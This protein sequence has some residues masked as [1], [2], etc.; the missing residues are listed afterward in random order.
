MSGEAAECWSKPEPAKKGDR[1]EGTK[2][3]G[4]DHLTLY[5][6]NAL[7]ASTFYVGRFGMKRV[8]YQGLETKQSNR[9]RASHVLQQGRI[10][11]KLVSAY[12]PGDEEFNTFMGAHGDAVK[13][14][15]FS[16]EN[17]RALYKRVLDAGAES[18]KEP[19]ELSDEN[20][21]VVIATIKSYGDVTHTF[22]ERR[23]YH[24][25]FLPGYEPVDGDKDPFT[26]ITAPVEL[27]FIDHVVGNHPDHCMTPIVEWY[28]KVFNFHRFWSVDD[29]IMHT[30]YSALNSTVMTDYDEVIKL[31]TNEPAKGKKKSQIQEYIDYHGGAGV[32]HVALNTSNILHSVALLKQRGLDFLTVP[33]TY[34]DRLREKLKTAAIKVEEDLDE[35]EKLNIL[36]DYDE[37]GYLLQIFTKP[38]EDRPT[39]FY[40]IIQRHNHYG[41]GAGNFKSLFEAIEK[42]QD[43]RGNLN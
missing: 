27:G 36:I 31:P 5:V 15:A 41:F 34:Y 14:I 1:P 22:I 3:Y 42:E 7:Q 8:A 23:D 4:F 20:G 2:Y 16:V 24:G 25:V 6:S 10:I 12:N 18:V 9:N 19:Y 33:R 39:L 38:V 17:A 43:R 35:V 30:D 40:E 37:K 32:Q 28:E 26:K 29:S 21:K 13:D 11:F